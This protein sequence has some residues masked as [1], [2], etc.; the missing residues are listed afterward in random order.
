MADT[1]HDAPDARPRLKLPAKTRRHSHRALRKAEGFAQLVDDDDAS[2]KGCT[3]SGEAAAASE[4]A[5]IAQNTKSRG[6][7]RTR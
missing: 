3:A 6:H 1:D 2:S 5:A 4:D 7:G